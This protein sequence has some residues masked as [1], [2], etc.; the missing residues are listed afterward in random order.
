MQPMRKPGLGIHMYTL[1]S[2]VATRR[3]IF[4]C[5]WAPRGR[6]GGRVD[7]RAKMQ[8]RLGEADGAT[9][10]THAHTVNVGGR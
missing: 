2:H 9:A 4:T 8:R 5:T 7:S 1:F 6:K 10:R 3:T